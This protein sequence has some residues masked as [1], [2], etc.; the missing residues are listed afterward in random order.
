MFLTVVNLYRDRWWS[1]LGMLGCKRCHAAEVVTATVRL[2]P[3]IPAM[4][5]H[6]TFVDGDSVE[7]RCNGDT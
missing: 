7:I 3:L 5:M 1:R 4:V 6:T 2:R